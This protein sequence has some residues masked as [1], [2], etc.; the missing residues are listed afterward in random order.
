MLALVGDDMQAQRCA[1]MLIAP[2]PDHLYLAAAR[3]VAPHIYVS[4]KEAAA[5]LRDP[6]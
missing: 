6:D 1:L 3:G 4:A 5:H 2:E